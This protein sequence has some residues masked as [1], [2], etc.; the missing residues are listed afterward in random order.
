MAFTD[1]DRQALIELVNHIQHS[2]SPEHAGADKDPGRITLPCRLLRAAAEVTE[3]VYD[4]DSVSRLDEAEV[5]MLVT[6]LSKAVDA[7]VGS[8]SQVVAGLPKQPPA[9]MLAKLDQQVESLTGLLKERETLLAAAQSVLEREEEVLA[10]QRRL[11]DL[12]QRHAALLRARERLEGTSIEELRREVEDL[13]SKLGPART[14][15]EQLEGR[16]SEGETALVAVSGALADARR[17]LGEQEKKAE[18]EFAKLVGVGESLVA[19]LAPH[20]ARC[21]RN[22]REIVREIGEKTAEGKQLRE[23]LTAR[24]EE[25]GTVY[26]ETAGLAEAL[27][28]YAQSDYQ[29]ALSVPGVVKTVRE[30]LSRIEEELREVDVEL[31]RALS[32]HQV[33][34]RVTAKVSF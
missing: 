6:Y 13:E 2:Y 9:E 1:K 27:K 26:D 33:A 24:L 29:V 22:I 25:V 31:A 5:E 19:A 8:L 15:L 12:R 28:L 17:R 14:E 30:R 18:E 16:L 21:Q 34:G 20:A 23:E 10:E 7:V 3:Q 4:P 32:Q 11:D